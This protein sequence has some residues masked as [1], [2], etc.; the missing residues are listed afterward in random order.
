MNVTDNLICSIDSML[1]RIEDEDVMQAKM[2]LLDYYSVFTAGYKKSDGLKAFAGFFDEPRSLKD[3]AFI[4]GYSGHILELD[5]GHRK[6]MSHPGVCVFSTLMP[7]ACRNNISG[8]ELI[9][10][11]IAGY[12]F[13]L[14]IACSI[15]PGHKKKGFHTTATCGT[16]GG[17]MAVAYAARYDTEAKKRILSAAVSAAAGT[18]ALQDDGSEMKPLNPAIAALNALTAVQAGMIGLQPP[19]DPLGG[20]RGFLRLYSDSFDEQFFSKDYCE[21]PLIRTIYRK[22]HASC[23]HSHSPVDCALDLRRIVNGRYDDIRKITVETY[24]LGIKGH[25]DRYFEN[26]NAARLSTPYCVACALLFGA[27]SAD[28]FKND[29]IENEKVCELAEK[30]FVTEGRSFTEALPEKRGAYVKIE[31]KDGNVYNSIVERPK[32]EPENP[33]SC[34]ELNKKSEK[35]LKMAGYCEDRI[36][37]ASEAV[38]AS[39]KDPQ[40]VYSLFKEVLK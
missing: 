3:E 34:D 31:M 39:D 21:K 30:V 19:R 15:Q 26:A 33:I 6:A 27:V 7:F 22:L 28:H 8:K 35:L 4:C 37:A 20:D 16:F 2:C 14:R 17:A 13:S 1:E 10:G 25:S 24:D 40:P 29:Y 9:K 36:I 23:R 11:I 18:L 38:Y 5:D 32:G 12:E